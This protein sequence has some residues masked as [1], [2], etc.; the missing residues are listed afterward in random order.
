MLYL[1]HSMLKMLYSCSDVEKSGSMVLTSEYVNSYKY[2]HKEG[3]YKTNGSITTSYD[4][5]GHKTGTYKT[6]SNG[7]TTQYDKQ[8]HKTGSYKT[9]SQGRT[10]EY[11]KYG[12]KVGS[13]K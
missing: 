1:S 8:G 13:Y 9:D 3:S 12:K 10:I 11:D 2:G 4:K 6:N 5:Y 7:V